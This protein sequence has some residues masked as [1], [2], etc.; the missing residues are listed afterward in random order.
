METQRKSPSIHEYRKLK[1][2]EAVENQQ[3]LLHLEKEA[4]KGIPSHSNTLTEEEED[5]SL[6]VDYEE[7]DDE[8]LLLKSSSEKK[9][10]PKTVDAQVP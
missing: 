8:S 5:P 6:Q 10:I 4:L 1:A 7:S 9:N 3:H 2:E